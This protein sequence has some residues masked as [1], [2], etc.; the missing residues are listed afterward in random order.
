M[1]ILVHILLLYIAVFVMISLVIVGNHIA[2]PNRQNER[3]P[4]RDSLKPF[5]PI[6]KTNIEKYNKLLY[7]GK[8]IARRAANSSDYEDVEK[9]LN[10]I[11]EKY[12]LSLPYSP[13]SKENIGEKRGRPK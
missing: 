5:K 4:Y 13:Q 9:E 7:I 12:G 3:D 6:V 11:P 8:E 2:F 10:G 1:D